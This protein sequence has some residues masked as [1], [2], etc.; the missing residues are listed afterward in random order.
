MDFSYARNTTQF[1]P[2]TFAPCHAMVVVSAS[3]RFVLCLTGGK[4]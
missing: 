4:E 3:F 1:T 2:H